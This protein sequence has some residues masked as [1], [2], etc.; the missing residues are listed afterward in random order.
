M[1]KF[2]EDFKDDFVFLDWLK[3]LSSKGR[4]IYLSKSDVF[5]AEDPSILN[6]SK[7]EFEEWIRKYHF[8]DAREWI[9]KFNNM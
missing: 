6:L 7:E 5:E 4:E 2:R 3:S 1:D 8:H 9:E